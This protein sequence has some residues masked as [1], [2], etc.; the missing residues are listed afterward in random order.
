MCFSASMLNESVAKKRL[1]NPNNAPALRT[2]RF[3]KAKWEVAFKSDDIYT[4]KELPTVHGSPNIIRGPGENERCPTTSLRCSQQHKNISEQNIW[5]SQ[6][7][8]SFTTRHVMLTATQTTSQEHISFP[9]H[10]TTLSLPNVW[11]SENICDVRN[12]LCEQIFT[13]RYRCP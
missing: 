9:Q 1:S 8:T 4:I 6:Q 12:K 13:R 2:L 7:Y 11:F 10:N 3:T 5:L